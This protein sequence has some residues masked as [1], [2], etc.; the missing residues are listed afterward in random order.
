M[1]KIAGLL[2]FIC[3]L[4]CEDSKFCTDI[5]KGKPDNNLIAES[6]F[7]T[8]RSLFSTN[9]LSLDNFLVYRLQ[10]DDLGYK[11]VRCYQYVNNLQVFSDDVIFHFN[12]QNKYYFLSGEIIS[13][14]NISSDPKM[15]KNEVMKL[16]LELVDDDGNY[17]SISLKDEC[18]QCEIGYYDLNAGTGN[19]TH[20][21][22]LAWKIKR[23]AS[24]F[25]FAY[26]NDTD[27]T[28]IYYDNGIRY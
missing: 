17:S 20:N 12:T 13:W 8:V 15:S 4:S 24:D 16:F 22:K 5:I 10:K 7:N 3:L 9:N 25:P 26:I 21:F 11:H 27:K 19:E 14:I 6:D 28:K 18:F 1:K 23:E 2:I